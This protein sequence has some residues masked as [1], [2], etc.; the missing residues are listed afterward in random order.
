[1]KRFL[2]ILAVG[3][4]PLT[5]S[6]CALQGHVGASTGHPAANRTA[7]PSRYILA[8]TWGVAA[9]DGTIDG[10]VGQIHVQDGSNPNS[11]DRVKFFFGNYG[12][13]V[14]DPFFNGMAIA[15]G[16]E[17]SAHRL[18]MLTTDTNGDGYISGA[19]DGIWMS[20]GV[21]LLAAGVPASAYF[22]DET[23]FVDTNGLGGA[24]L[25]T[26]TTEYTG[27][28]WSITNQ[29]PTRPNSL[30]SELP[31]QV[32]AQIMNSVN[33]QSDVRRD[34]S[35]VEWIKLHVNEVTLWGSVYVPNGLSLE[36]GLDGRLHVLNPRDASLRM[37]AS[38]VAD[39]FEL[40]IN[41]GETSVSGSVMINGLTFDSA[42]FEDALA[43]RALINLPI[44]STTVDAL[45]DFAS[46]RFSRTEDPLGRFGHP[47]LRAPG[48]E[49]GGG[50]TSPRTIRR[51]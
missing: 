41:R 18:S 48:A 35:G 43:G 31:F 2:G 14:F 36:S 9:P 30:F 3:V 47:E 23:T 44:A 20:S 29:D 5:L 33:T 7:G 15:S 32:R 8:S 49:L 24:G 28:G 12:A 11:V 21:G 13:F 26:G 37:L 45:R 6:G 27:A 51:F 46:G 42:Q 38:W 50:T 34:E 17:G 10:G 19:P 39:Q 40:A 22:L 1:M 25:S 16:P 4:L